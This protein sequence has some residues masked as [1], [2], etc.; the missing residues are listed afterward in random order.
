MVLGNKVAR[1]L[2]LA[3]SQLIARNFH[4]HR[5]MK[6]RRK[7]KCVAGLENRGD[8]PPF[9]TVSTTSPIMPGPLKIA[10]I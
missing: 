3:T 2:Q 4:V 9:K 5:I 1:P 6:K 10:V 7:T 8:T